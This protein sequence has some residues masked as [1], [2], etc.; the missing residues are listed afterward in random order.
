MGS[1]VHATIN[2]NANVLQAEARP[3]R[4]FDALAETEHTIF[5]VT[6]TLE[7]LIKIC[8]VAHDSSK[9]TPEAVDDFTMKIVQ[10]SGYE[11]PEEFTHLIPKQPTSD[12]ETHRQQSIKARE[13]T[14]T[15]KSPPI[16]NVVKAIE[17][18]RKMD[19]AGKQIDAVR[20]E[21]KS[22]PESEEAVAMQQLQ[23]NRSTETTE[24]QPIREQARADEVFTRSV[25]IEQSNQPVPKPKEPALQ[26]VKK[27]DKIPQPQNMAVAVKEISVGDI[28]VA[29]P[30]LS[31]LIEI[32]N[33]TAPSSV[34][35][36]DE[37]PMF[38]LEDAR[39][40]TDILELPLLPPDGDV[41]AD[42]QFQ[43]F[44]RPLYFDA[45]DDVEDFGL[46]LDAL[47]VIK[48][49]QALEVF[50]QLP[51]LLEELSPVESEIAHNLTAQIIDI[52]Q[53]LLDLPETPA[54]PWEQAILHKSSLG[55]EDS[56]SVVEQLEPQELLAEL[57]TELCGLVN[58]ECDS[59]LA[60]RLV[61]VM[62]VSNDILSSEIGQSNA[63]IVLGAIQGTHEFLQHVMNNFHK[64]KQAI[65]PHGLIGRCALSLAA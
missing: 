58:I 48:D 29:T 6:G 2:H 19:I 62:L 4:L 16:V 13:I 22:R 11:V 14:E 5:G 43:P 38:V 9:M 30:E 10:T 65:A 50:E 23:L 31:S 1:E 25:V 42:L 61:R 40:S 49:T 12:E 39:E 57:I 24:A 20:V 17:V 45:T 64:Y 27:I 44:E 47:A 51:E 52:A 28:S 34:L 55:T 36:L 3:T 56:N 41:L 15:K 8:P 46:H 33:E 54:S 60:I 21:L 37:D 32:A 63:N 18:G 26:K 59:E 7:Q 35:E 53:H